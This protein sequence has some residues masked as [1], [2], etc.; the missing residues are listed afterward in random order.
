[1]FQCFDVGEG[2]T[3]FACGNIGPSDE[4]VLLVEEEV[5]LGVALRDEERGGCRFIVEGE[6]VGIGEDINVVNEDRVSVGEEASSLLESPT[7]L[8]ELISLIAETDVNAKGVIG[9]DKVND[10]LSEMMDINDD[11]SH[12]YGFQFLNE[13]LYKGFAIDGHHRL[14][15]GVGERFETS[16]ETGCEDE[17][18]HES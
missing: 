12:T 9:L 17:S 11:F 7:R 14:G 4:T 18:V 5:T 1:M 3:D 6:E 13:Y 15:H 8:K 16:A 10:L 2:G